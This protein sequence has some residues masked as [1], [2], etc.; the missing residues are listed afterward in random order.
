METKACLDLKDRLFYGEMR[1]VL[2]PTDVLLCMS[3]SGTCCNYQRDNVPGLAFEKEMYDLG[4][5]EW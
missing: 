4:T 1:S 2:S 5:A 3:L